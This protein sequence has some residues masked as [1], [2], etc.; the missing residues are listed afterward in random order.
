MYNVIFDMDG[1]IFDSER[2]LLACWI[3]T[4]KKYDLNEDLIRN[5]YMQCIGT[6]RN[7][8][9]QIFRNAFCHILSDEMQTRI[10]DE[11]AQL[12]KI[13]Y[14]DGVLPIKPGV[15]EILDFLQSGGISVGVASSTKRQKVEQQIRNAGLYD[16][17]V[18]FIGGDAVKVSKPNPEIYLLACRAFGFAPSDTFAIEDSFNGIRAAHAAGMR[19][20]MVPDMVPADDE[21]KRLA[22]TVCKDLIETMDYLK[23]T[24]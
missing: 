4:S 9:T 14:A 6:N 15:V 17:F 8:S 16:Y 12:H 19:P 2:T 11:S 21:M 5:T 24:V 10:W 3:E 7:Q 1:V 18:G 22:E 23:K 13:R 20:I